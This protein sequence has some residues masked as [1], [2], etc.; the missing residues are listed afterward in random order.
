MPIVKVY[1]LPGSF[2]GHGC[3]IELKQLLA[4]TTAANIPNLPASQVTVFLPRDMDAEVGK[5]CVIFVDGL[6]NRSERTS[7]VRKQLARGLVIALSEFL[8]KR[9][10]S[11][12]SRLIE[13]FV[14]PFD[15][16]GGFAAGCYGAER[17]EG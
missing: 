15:P 16:R 6:F 8:A 9:C 13:C 3:L 10:P 14:R 12:R 5:E 17:N 11:T 2:T 7:D 4:A 1:G